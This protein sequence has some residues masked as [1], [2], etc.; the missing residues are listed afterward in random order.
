M[1]ELEPCVSVGSRF[2]AFFN[3]K[4]AYNW[5]ETFMKMYLY[6]LHLHKLD[7]SEHVM[8]FTVKNCPKLDKN[9]QNG[10]LEA[11]KGWKIEKR[12]FLSN[13]GH[14][15]SRGPGQCFEETRSKYLKSEKKNP[16]WLN[17]FHRGSPLLTG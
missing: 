4:W 2:D 15:F 1:N 16:S 5:C 17:R 10:L 3:K 14:W 9:D 8:N 6:I 11:K 7:L 12:M 13:I